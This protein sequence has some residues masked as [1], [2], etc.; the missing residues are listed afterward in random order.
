MGNF[1]TTSFKWKIWRKVTIKKKFYKNLIFEEI[2]LRF[3]FIG[4]LKRIGF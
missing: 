1:T 4:Y 3:A 2:L